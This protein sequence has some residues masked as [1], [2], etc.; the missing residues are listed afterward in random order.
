[1][2]VYQLLSA[3][4]RAYFCKHIP[5][6]MG[7][8]PRHL[9]KVS[10]SGADL[11]LLINEEKR[12]VTSTRVILLHLPGREAKARGQ[13]PA[14]LEPPMLHDAEPSATY[15]LGGTLGSLGAKRKAAERNCT[16]MS[17]IQRSSV[18]MPTAPLD[19]SQKVL[20]QEGPGNEQQMTNDNG[21]WMLCSLLLCFDSF[22]L[23][24]LLL[25]ILLAVACSCSHSFY[26]L[27]ALE[28][29]HL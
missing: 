20:K 16:N 6:E 29:R 23:S 15:K 4:R 22:C 18:R 19:S 9:S 24:R 17:T 28:R 2:V 27:E 5:I 26:I 10:G 11:I 1:M 13:E 7:G 14:L 25:P 3:K 12:L 21:L 8:T